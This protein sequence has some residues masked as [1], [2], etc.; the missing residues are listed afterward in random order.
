MKGLRAATPTLL[1]LAAALVFGI[2]L[3]LL[4]GA[5]PFEALWLLVEGSFGSASKI[6]ATLLAW[7][8]LLL[9]SAGLV[10]TFAA[11][12]WNIGV[13]GQVIVGAI[14]ATWVARSLPG[15]VWVILPATIIAG[16][17]GGL[18]WALIVGVLKTH[19]GVHEIFGGLG[20][21]FVAA[22]LAV[23][24]VLGPWQRTG[25]A[26]TSGTDIFREEAW[27]P[28]IEALGTGWPVVPV[29]LGLASV[30][31]VW[32]L[33]RGTRFGLRLKAVGRNPQSSFLIGIPTNSYMLGAFAIGG[34]L[35]GIAGTVQATGFHHKLVPAV[36]GG[37]GFLGI[38]V[39]LLA[40]FSAA[41]IA[42]IA[43]FFIAISVGSTQ[44]DLRL[45][46]DSAYGGVLQGIIVLFVMIGGA[47]SVRR[48]SVSAT[49]RGEP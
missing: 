2:V 28:E 39:V 12:L 21:D 37:Y 34:A 15:P 36:S 44:L 14:A 1:S 40:S 29:I 7:S 24:L 31:I 16:A 47:W 19:G 8:P 49:A 25:V 3:L 13:E 22:G 4:S 9:A 26:S 45:G 41:W 20:L 10:I 32:L 30:L 5:P 17:I 46:L 11:G 43:L 18:V 23:Y 27:M 48:T 38:L 6:S 33:L 35:A 42:P